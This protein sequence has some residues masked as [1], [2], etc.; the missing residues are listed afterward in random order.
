MVPQGPWI[1]GSVS[2]ELEST[3]VTPSSIVTISFPS[4]P[5]LAPPL[6]PSFH[7]Y[8]SP[9]PHSGAP[10]LATELYTEAG[11]SCS[12][13]RPHLNTRS[14]PHNRLSQQISKCGPRSSDSGSISWEFL[15]NPN[16]EAP[17][18]TSKP[19]MLA[20]RPR[21]L[22]SR[23]FC[24]TQ[25]SESLVHTFRHPFAENKIW[26]YGRQFPSLALI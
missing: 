9:C 18:W 16:S 7:F 14:V 20:M 6:P 26:A 10:C 8:P 3:T 12:G 19:K 4:L 13:H 1:T 17:P 22:S 25:V 24:H 21:S 15:T 11:I 2:P 5:L 23:Q